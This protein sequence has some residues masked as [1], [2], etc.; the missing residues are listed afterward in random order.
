MHS[1]GR[2]YYQRNHYSKGAVCQW[3][4]ESMCGIRVAGENRFTIAPLPGGSLTHAEA[5]YRSVYGL[6]KSGWTSENGKTVYA[7]AVPANCEAELRLPG[8]RR[9]TLAAGSYTFED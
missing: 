3:L 1:T 4:F 6:V 7:V 5:S 8:G 9:E 2:H